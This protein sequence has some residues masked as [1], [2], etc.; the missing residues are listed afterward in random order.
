MSQWNRLLIDEIE[1]TDVAVNSVALWSLGGAGVVLRTSESTIL[2]DPYFGPSTSEEWVRMVAVPLDPRE[3]TACDLLLSTHEHEDHC[4]RSTALAVA[5]RTNA[6]FIG[7]E[8]SCKRFL[9]WGI[10]ESRVIS[11]KPG[12][13]VD[14]KD[15]SIVAWF[16]NDPDAES[17]ISYII[18][19]GDIKVFH[20][21]DSKFSES[22]SRVGEREGVDVAILALGRN[23][24]GHKYYMNACDLVEAARDLG[25]RT[26]IPVHWDIWRRTREDPE[27]VRDIARRWGLTL[28]VVALQLGDRYVYKKA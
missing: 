20:G 13:R 5:E 26:L 6:K 9:M 18:K 23:P 22:F 17:A 4:E 1:D 8:S 2:I 3:L 10:E 14:H 11:L 27:L 12:E 28:E 24:R 21:G 25:A 16:A 7:P 15:I 19:S